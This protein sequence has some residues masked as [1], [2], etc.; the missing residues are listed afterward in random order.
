MSSL[1]DNFLYMTHRIFLW[2]L[3]GLMGIAA[4]V[5]MYAA[6]GYAD[7]EE[8]KAQLHNSLVNFRRPMIIEFSSTT[9]TSTRPRII[10]GY[11]TTTA[12]S[13]KPKVIKDWKGHVASTTATTTATTTRPAPRPGR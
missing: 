8:Q 5:F 4:W 1:I 3:V 6:N 10:W 11:S 13:T 9:G 12:T 2:V 7:I